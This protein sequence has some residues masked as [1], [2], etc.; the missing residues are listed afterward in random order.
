MVVGKFYD[1]EAMAKAFKEKTLEKIDFIK[2]GIYK[3]GVFSEFGARRRVSYELQ[4]RLVK[5]L[6]SQR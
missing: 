1:Y 4:D 6:K 3:P 2:R 5:T